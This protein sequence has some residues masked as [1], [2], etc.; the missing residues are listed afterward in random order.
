MASKSR[1]LRQR[2]QRREKRQIKAELRFQFDNSRGCNINDPIPSLLK[3]V[4][5]PGDFTSYAIRETKRDI[6][7]GKIENG[8]IAVLA[9]AIEMQ[10]E[11]EKKRKQRIKADLLNK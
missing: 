4:N 9:K 11:I 1:Q 3:N 5:L 6:Q 8:R 2:E 7:E 10:R